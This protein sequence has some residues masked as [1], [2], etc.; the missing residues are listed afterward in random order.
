MVLGP[1]DG[2]Y[3]LKTSTASAAAI[4]VVGTPLDVLKN[5]AQGQIM[6]KTPVPNVLEI[7]KSIKPQGVRAFWAGFLPSMAHSVLTPGIFFALYEGQ[8]RRKHCY[9]AGVMARM[10]SFTC[11]QPFE[12]M[13]T[14]RQANTGTTSAEVTAYLDRDVWNI[15]CTDGLPSLWRGWWAT[16]FQ[17]L[18]FSLLAW[19]SYESILR[20]LAGESEGFDEERNMLAELGA[21]KIG[22]A[23]LV[24]GVFAGFLTHPF[25]VIKTQ[26]QIHLRVQSDSNSGFTRNSVARF[27]RTGKN[28]YEAAGIGGFYA[29]VVP[30][31]SR[32]AIAAVVLG[33]LFEFVHPLH[34]DLY[35]PRR[36]LL[37]LGDDPSKVI[38]HPRNVDRV[39][40]EFGKPSGGGGGRNFGGGAFG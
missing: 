11:V 32:I 5:A 6:P 9:A 24:S 34:E 25:D 30:R 17:T 7:A 28:V 35:R 22:G 21:T 40:V 37:V 15:I 27:I 26:Q 19:T 4:C 2:E 13:R 3:I 1:R 8:R 31:M 33:P 16:M 29:G 38:A 20:G 14:I 39:H 10:F 36:Q 18:S 23:A 12:Y